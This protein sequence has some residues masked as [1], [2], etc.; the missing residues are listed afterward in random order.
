MLSQDLLLG[1]AK[2]HKMPHCGQPISGLRSEPWPPNYKAT[3]ST[4]VSSYYCP[5]LQD[6]CFA[7]G[8]GISMQLVRM[9]QPVAFYDMNE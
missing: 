5:S 8:Q 3:H 2:N 9:P 4:V 6:V 7:S 1:I